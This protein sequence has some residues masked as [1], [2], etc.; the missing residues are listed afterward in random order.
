[1]PL[2]TILLFRSE[3]STPDR[4]PLLYGGATA[5]LARKD[6]RGQEAVEMLAET[7]VL[8]VGR[9]RNR[10]RRLMIMRPQIL[11]TSRERAPILVLFGVTYR[12]SLAKSKDDSVSLFSPSQSC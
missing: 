4:F 12:Q 11:P 7:A 6:E 9:V 1:M 10:L 8:E 2:G 5:R 3:R